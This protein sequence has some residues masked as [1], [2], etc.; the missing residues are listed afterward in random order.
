MTVI[1]CTLVSM[2]AAAQ[3]D[4]NS[5]LTGRL[6]QVQEYLDSAAMKKVDPHYIEVPKKPWRVIL[7]YK[8]TAVDVDY[9]NHI[10]LPEWN[11]SSDWQLCMK[12]PASAS[13][14]VWVGY[15][16]TGIS[17]SKSL[18]K[19]SGRHFSF[20]TTG[21]RYGFNFRL[22]RFNASEVSFQATDYKDGK[23]EGT[24]FDTVYHTPAP[25]RG[26]VCLY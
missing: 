10:D 16:G 19:N 22:R 24:P 15:R 9:D 2:K 4:S 25:Y 5:T 8:Q 6:H 26:P 23:T 21:A 3:A 12:P 1:C 7:R 14:G 11:E 20:S 18:V 17:Y 13:V